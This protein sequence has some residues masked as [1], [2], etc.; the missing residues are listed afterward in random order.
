VLR[1]AARRATVRDIAE[2]CSTI[3]ELRGEAVV[4]CAPELA[5]DI[6]SE[7]DWRYVQACDQPAGLAI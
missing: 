1:L 5:F 4:G 6:D 2:R 3:L 7:A